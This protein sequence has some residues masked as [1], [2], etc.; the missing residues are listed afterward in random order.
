M[1]YW[2]RQPN[3]VFSEEYRALLRTIVDAR[4]DAGLSQR[5]LAARIG[6]CPSHV[7]MIERGQR[8]IDALELYRMAKAFAIDPAEL[9]GRIAQRI[10]TEAASDAPLSLA[11]SAPM[12][13]R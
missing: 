13:T 10:E 1:T 7:G 6:K 5:D 9:F 8:R 2:V 3:T 12:R 11:Q 4:K